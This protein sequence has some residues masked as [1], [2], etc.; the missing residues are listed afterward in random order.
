MVHEKDKVGVI[1]PR[2]K[3]LH[4]LHCSFYCSIALWVFGAA[5]LMENSTV[6]ELVLQNT[7]TNGAAE[8]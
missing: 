4:C 3:S 8:Y 7:D 2:Q 1:I 6:T 5:C